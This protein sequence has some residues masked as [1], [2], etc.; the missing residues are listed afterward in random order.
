MTILILCDHFG[1][2]G[3][4]G[5]V[6][7]NLAEALARDHKVRVLTAHVMKDFVPGGY[8]VLNFDLDYPSG[9]RNYKGLYHGK[10]VRI[11]KTHLAQNRYDAALVHNLHT[12]WSYHCLKVLSG[13]GIKTVLA[14]HDVAA[15]TPYVKLCHVRPG[16]Y[17]YPWYRHLREA[18]F[19]YNPLRNYLIR[20]YLRYASKTVAVSHELKKALEQNGI[21]VDSVIHNGINS[22]AGEYHRVLYDTPSD[23]IFFGGRVSEAKG[24]LQAVKF[25]EALKSGY[26]LAPRLM[27]AG[28]EGA[29]TDKMKRLAENLGVLGQLKF[30]GWL[31][32]KSYE[33]HLSAAGIVM[34]PSICFDSFPTV[35]LEAMRQAKPVVATALGGA[36]E[37][38]EHEKTGYIAD[39]FDV[40]GF[41]DIIAKLLLNPGQAQ[42]MG[43][44]GFEQ[45]RKKF[46]IEETAAN[47][48][49]ILSSS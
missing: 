19:R 8:E 45:V 38:V 43:R 36:G 5:N 4:A 37:M 17:H 18:K 35:I 15:F 22:D 20:K 6:A 46:R 48:L 27:V 41:S 34:V 33:R 16:E 39:P 9:F 32:A 10:A 47:Y 11:L 7:F 24:S 12:N 21:E 40:P 23:T 31:E 29:A 26:G 42:D 49:R 1:T 14:F 3:G 2:G 25:L 13:A 28:H 30:L 44:A